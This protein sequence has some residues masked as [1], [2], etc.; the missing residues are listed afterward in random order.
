MVEMN[1]LKDLITLVVDIF[2]RPSPKDPRDHPTNNINSDTSDNGYEN[3]IVMN[4]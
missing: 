1:Y 2:F 3:V 4:Y